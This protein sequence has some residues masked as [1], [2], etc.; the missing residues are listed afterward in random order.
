MK[1]QNKAENEA[2]YTAHIL[3]SSKICSLERIEFGF[4]AQNSKFKLQV[5]N[6]IYIIWKHKNEVIQH[7]KILAG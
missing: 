1:L 3:N 7:M 2:S 6:V 5:M 4:A